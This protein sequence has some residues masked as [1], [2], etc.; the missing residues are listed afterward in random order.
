MTDYHYTPRQ[1]EEA[2]R[3]NLSEG[4]PGGEMRDKTA[5]WGK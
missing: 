5:D 2:T 3:F 4:K 1:K